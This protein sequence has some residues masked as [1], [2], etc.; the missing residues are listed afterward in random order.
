MFVGVTAADLE[1]F[2]C[3]ASDETC[4]NLLRDTISLLGMDGGD[5]GNGKNHS[6]VSRFLVL[7]D[8]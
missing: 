1:A 4:R 2:D 7:F 8:E 6:D 3:W 5:P